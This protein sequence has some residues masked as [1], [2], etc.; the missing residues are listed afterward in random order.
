MS[1]PR[2]L[3]HNGL[4]AYLLKDFDQAISLKTGNEIEWDEVKKTGRVFIK[5]LLKTKTKIQV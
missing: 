2:L 4:T 5:L 1:K 3:T